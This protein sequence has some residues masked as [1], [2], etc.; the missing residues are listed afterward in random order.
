MII[1]KLS[2]AEWELIQALTQSLTLRDLAKKT[3]FSLSTTWRIFKNLYRKGAYYYVFDT[4]RFRLCYLAVISAYDEHGE[5]EWPQGTLSIRKLWGLKPYTLF[6]ALIPYCFI[7]KYLKSL[8]A[9]LVTVVRGLEVHWWRPD[10]GGSLLMPRG[11]LV[12]FLSETLKEK[13]FEEKYSRPPEPPPDNL[14]V[15][16]PIDMAILVK[17]LQAG[18]FARPIEGV[19]YAAN[20]D[21]SFP[22]V[23]EK[24]V[25]YH[26]RKHVLPSWL[27]NTFVPYLPITDV[28]LRIFYFEGREAPA[29]ARMLITLPYFITALVDVNCS[30]LT[31]QTPA[32]MMETIYRVVSSFDVEAPLCQPV[33]SSENIAKFIPHLWKFLKKTGKGWKWSWPEEK[34]RVIQRRR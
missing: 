12:P 3:G 23:S 33:M 8:N 19:R 18:P 7:D 29:V 13:Y 16:D 11:G 1:A 28:P 32:W 27:Y 20:V 17:K 21:P 26:Y 22:R 30:L 5:N 31:G 24:T 2:R 10:S 15:P 34:V 14:T 25:S 9:D 4:R 6:S